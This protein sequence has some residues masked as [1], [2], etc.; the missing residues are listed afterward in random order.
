MNSLLQV[1]VKMDVPKE[2]NLIMETRNVKLKKIVLCG[3]WSPKRIY[4]Q[5]NQLCWYSIRWQRSQRSEINFH[6]K[7]TRTVNLQWKNVLTR[8]VKKMEISICGQWPIQT[9][10]SYPNQQY[11]VSTVDCAR[12]R[13]VNPQDATR[14]GIMT[15]TVNCNLNLKELCYYHY[16]FHMHIAMTTINMW[17]VPELFCS[18]PDL[19]VIGL[20][21]AWSN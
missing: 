18:I 9:I 5:M 1:Q 8:I 11:H 4:G 17:L 19:I 15:K 2:N 13:T 21:T 14:K 16:H 7:M 3:Q 10:C 6:K 12:T 20:Y